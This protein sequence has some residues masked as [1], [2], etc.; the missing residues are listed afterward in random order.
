M[1]NRTKGTKRR[2]NEVKPKEFISMSKDAFRQWRRHSALQRASALAFFTIFPLPSLLLI[3]TA[4]LA[5]V[6][7]QAEAAQQ[8]LQ[9]I[10]SVVGP[11]IAGLVGQLIE[12]ARSPFTS[13]LA[14]IVS[15]AFTVSGALGAFGVLQDSLNTIWNVTPAKERTL[16]AKVQGKIFPFLFVSGLGIIIIVWSGITPILFNLVNIAFESSIG[17][18]MLLIATSLLFSF[19]LATFLFAIIYQKIPDTP[20]SWKD[21]RLAA[22]I[23]GLLFTIGNYLFTIYVQ[24]FSATSVYGA[25][26]SLMALLLWIYLAA[27]FLLFGA[28]FSKIYAETMGSRSKRNKPT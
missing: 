23:T 19:M 11:A 18:S 6:Y 17:F 21:V 20:I 2:Y 5:Q 15:I 26:G 27:Q 9:Q 22:I 8:V 25:A 12:S 13:V 24:T 16:K 1:L 7:G 3:I 28:E 4:I 14:A 10:T